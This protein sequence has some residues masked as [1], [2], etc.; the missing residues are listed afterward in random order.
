MPG[1]GT[2]TPVE[3]TED[4]T[5]SFYGYSRRERGFS[6]PD[7]G[8][9]LVQATA[10]V[11]ALSLLTNMGLLWWNFRGIRRYVEEGQVGVRDEAY[12]ESET[13]TLI[14]QDPGNAANPEVSIRIP[15]PG[16]EIF[17]SGV[18]VDEAQALVAPAI[19]A[20]NV[21][22]NA[23]GAGYGFKGGY[24]NTARRNEKRAMPNIVDPTA[25]DAAGPGTP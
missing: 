12:G 21:W 1:F 25:G 5:L 4:V 18:L 23:S 14:W 3:V 11:Q 13:A 8:G 16:A 15:A 20:M 6:F 7:N 10:V 24:K 2:A 17:K 19:T 9:T 22:L